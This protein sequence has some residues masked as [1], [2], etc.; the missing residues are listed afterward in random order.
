MWNFLMTWVMILNRRTVHNNVCK[1]TS[2]PGLSFWRWKIKHHESETQKSN[3]M[4]LILQKWSCILVSWRT[5]RTMIQVTRFSKWSSCHECKITFSFSN[6]LQF[7]LKLILLI[8]VEKSDFL[9]LALHFQ[10][11][12]FPIVVNPCMNF[13]SFDA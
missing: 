2:T 11:L 7:R 12:K 10:C 3:I 5:N 6:S 8:F 4:T 1:N 13:V 9:T